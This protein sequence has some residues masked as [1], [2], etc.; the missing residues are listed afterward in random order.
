TFS[1]VVR[2][3]GNASAGP[4]RVSFYLSTNSVIST[5]DRNVSSCTYTSLG[6]GTSNTCSGPLTIPAGLAPGTYRG[7]AIVDDLS[8]VDESVEDNHLMTAS[9]TISIQ[10]AAKPDLTVTSVTLPSRATSAAE[11]TFSA[12]VRNQGNASAG[13]FRVSFYLSTN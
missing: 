13:S 9:N 6:A 4:F 2:N 5:T 8:Q 10:Q 1:A 3:Q 7:G 11:L 12:V